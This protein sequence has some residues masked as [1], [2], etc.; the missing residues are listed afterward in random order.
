MFSYVSVLVCLCFIVLMF[1]HVCALLCLCIVIFMLCYV[2]FLLCLFFVC[3]FV[4][5]GLQIVISRF[6]EHG[7]EGIKDMLYANILENYM[8]GL[9]SLCFHVYVLIC[10]C[11]V[12]FMFYYVHVLL[13]LCS[14]VLMLCYVYV[15][16]VS[17]LLWIFAVIPKGIKNRLYANI[18]EKG[19]L[20]LL[21]LLI[22]ILLLLLSLLSSFL[23]FMFGFVMLMFCLFRLLLCY[24]YVKYMPEL[25][26]PNFENI[27]CTWVGK[28]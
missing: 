25:C 8:Y 9:L 27:L 24:V 10:L 3:S 17:V 16:C 20:L 12:M 1:C 28:E 6:S 7:G 2:Y 15:C 21:L 4:F 22:I 23:V 5:K 19:L 11:S 26:V 14:L 18:L 13:C